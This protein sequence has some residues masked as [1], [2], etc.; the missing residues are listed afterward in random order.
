MFF[1]LWTKTRDERTDCNK[2]FTN[3]LYISTLV[4]IVLAVIGAGASTTVLFSGF[5]MMVLAAPHTQGADQA[6]NGTG[7]KSN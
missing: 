4:A 3:L 7:Y 5:T 1:D 2:Y 6:Q